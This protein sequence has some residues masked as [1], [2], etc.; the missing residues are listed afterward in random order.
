MKNLTRPLNI[1]IRHSPLLFTACYFIYHGA[2]HLIIFIHILYY[3]YDDWCTTHLLHRFS[4]VGVKSSQQLSIDTD[5]I[6]LMIELRSHNLLENIYY[7]ILYRNFLSH[8]EDKTK[9][10]TKHWV[11]YIFTT[12]EMILSSNTAARLLSQSILNTHVNAPGKKYMLLHHN[13]STNE[14]LS[15]KPLRL[16][17]KFDGESE[18][19]MYWYNS[20]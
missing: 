11:I 15:S 6:Y 20:S 10:P 16:D 17:G 2:G 14:V 3:I 1:V 4:V 7:F 12:Y 19:Y 5:E 13:A 18:I 8:F 9:T